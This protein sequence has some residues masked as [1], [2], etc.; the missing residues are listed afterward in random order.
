MS[1]RGDSL[2]ERAMLLAQSEAQVE[3]EEGIAWLLEHADA[4]RPVLVDAVRAG[5]CSSQEVCMR[6]LAA[7]GGRGSVEALETALSRG[8]DGESFYA[9]VALRELGELGVGVLERHRN[10]ESESV[11]R[12]VEHVLGD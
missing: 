9:A 4:A 1:D 12:A 3:R 6:V 7:I 10:H 5:S 8:H 11:R 2:V